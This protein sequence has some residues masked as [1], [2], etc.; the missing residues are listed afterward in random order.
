M[1][2]IYTMVPVALGDLKFRVCAGVGAG[3]G[4]VSMLVLVLVSSVL[5][6]F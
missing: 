4:L 3:V 5:V 6:S 1:F 2:R